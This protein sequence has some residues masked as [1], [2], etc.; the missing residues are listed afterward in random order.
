[1]NRGPKILGKVNYGNNPGLC[2]HLELR[3]FVDVRCQVRR[4][5]GRP[6]NYLQSQRA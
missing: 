4:S 5:E 1:V 6:V 2:V 3:V